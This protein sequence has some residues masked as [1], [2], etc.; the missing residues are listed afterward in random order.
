MTPS[1]SKDRTSILEKERKKERKNGG[2]EE[3]DN[4]Y[5]VLTGYKEKRKGPIKRTKNPTCDFRGV[6]KHCPAFFSI[7]FFF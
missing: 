6:A 1:R 3:K 5:G 2:K 7:N 4:C